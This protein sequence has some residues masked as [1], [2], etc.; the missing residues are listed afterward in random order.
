MSW[1]GNRK[2]RYNFIWPYWKAEDSNEKLHSSC[3]VIA[4]W[5][6]IN[7][8]VGF[9]IAVDI[10]VDKGKKVV[11]NYICHV[12]NF[13]FGNLRVITQQMTTSSVSNSF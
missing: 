13:F 12:L 6:R 9:D 2:Q 1:S 11:K 7:T 8:K 3:F 5:K 4:F 10:A